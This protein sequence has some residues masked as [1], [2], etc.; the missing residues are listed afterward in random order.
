[1]T[2]EDRLTRLERHLSETLSG[3]HRI[4]RSINKPHEGKRMEPLID[5]IRAYVA[6]IPTHECVACGYE[7][8][9]ADIPCPDCGFPPEHHLCRPPEAD[10]LLREVAALE[11]V[12]YRYVDYRP[13]MQKPAIGYTQNPDEFGIPDMLESLYTLTGATHD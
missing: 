3:C 10:A 8:Q 7:F 4:L 11:P 1:M 2:A 6:A 13:W 5:R 12:A 9:G